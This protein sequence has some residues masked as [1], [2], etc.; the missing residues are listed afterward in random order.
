MLRRCGDNTHWVQL[1]QS[2]NC[3]ISVVKWNYRQNETGVLNWL[4]DAFSE[5]NR[6]IADRSIHAK[7]DRPER[8][9]STQIVGEIGLK[10]RGLG[11]ADWPGSISD[12]GVG[13][14]WR[15]GHAGDGWNSVPDL[16]E[17]QG[18][19]QAKFLKETCQLGGTGQAQGLPLRGTRGT[20]ARHGVGGNER[21]H[22]QHAG[23]AAP[24]LQGV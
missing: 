20:A 22:R 24:T 2:N 19:R 11:L 17:T 18:R 1:K 15:G 4:L 9:N 12:F 8:V 3:V 21:R 13:T 6:I 23:D 5:Q 10:G 16:G 14:V 7:I